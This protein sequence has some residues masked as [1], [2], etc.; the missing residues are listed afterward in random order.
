MS[1]LHRLPLLL[2][3]AF[4]AAL[5]AAP[6]AHAAATTTTSTN[7]SG[8]AVHRSGVRFRTASASWRQPAATCLSATASY[9]SFW[10]GIGG[11]RKTSRALE[12]IGT[13][14]DCSSDGAETTS[15]WYELV[16]AAAHTIHMTIEP[17]DRLSATVTVDGAR[18]SV[19]LRDRT[20][21]TEFTRTVV[22]H[23]LDVTSAEWIT[24]APSD[25]SGSD[26]TVLPLADFGTAHFLSAAATTTTGVTRSLTNAPW[27]RTRISL[28]S[29]FEQT[30]NGADQETRVTATPS[31]LSNPLGAFTVDY[32][33]SSKSITTPEPTGPPSTGPGGPGGPPSSSGRRSA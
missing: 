20:R 32:S 26:C 15:A 5:L 8:Y 11:Y 22:D 10:V 23:S 13:E 6:A 21:G 31:A 30:T 16:P 33:S 24:E 14:L 29:S 9:S 17:G 27:T 4:A 25:C 7:W 1:S 2:G 28:G 12:Q 18:V 19:A 3:G